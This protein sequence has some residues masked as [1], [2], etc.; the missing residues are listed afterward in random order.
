MKTAGMMIERKI[1]LRC[2]SFKF[3]NP[4]SS[5]NINYETINATRY[6]PF[7]LYFILKAMQHMFSAVLATAG[8]LTEISLYV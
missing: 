1:Y 2:F 4:T 6:A 8:T 5:I 7:L 3:L